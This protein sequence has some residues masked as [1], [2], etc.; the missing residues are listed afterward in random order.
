MSAAAVAVES[1]TLDYQQEQ[2]CDER[3][4]MSVMGG[5]EASDGELGSAAAPLCQCGSELSS[6]WVVFVRLRSTRCLPALLLSLPFFTLLSGRLSRWL[7]SSTLH[8]H[9]PPPPL[10]LHLVSSAVTRCRAVLHRCDSLLACTRSLP[11]PSPIP[12]TM[13]SSPPPAG[14]DS[15]NPASFSAHPLSS[16]T[17]SSPLYTECQSTIERHYRLH[18]LLLS[19]SPPSPL[20]DDAS[21]AALELSVSRLDVQLQ[22]LILS[23]S[24]YSQAQATP[25][26]PHD[27]QSLQL[28]SDHWKVRSSRAQH[29]WPLHPACDSRRGGCVLGCCHTAVYQSDEQRDYEAAVCTSPT[30]LHCGRRSHRVSAT[31]LTGH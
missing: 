5:R 15:S 10:H 14:G 4:G 25:P 19:S 24:A 22:A 23:M 13:S 3:C 28:A 12:A 26:D 11:L 8:T 30:A 18:Q 27:K 31:S 1:V 29:C 7:P 16:L 17:P 9:F 20:T 2:R 6:V 21:S